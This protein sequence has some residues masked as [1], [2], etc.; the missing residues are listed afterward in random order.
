MKKLL[1]LLKKL[2]IFFNKNI[3][4]V[5]TITQ[6]NHGEILKGKR[7]LITG[8]TSGI[9]LALAKKCLSEGAV[10][11]I[12]GRSLERLENISKE[13]SNK[14]LKVLEWNVKNI[15]DIDVNIE[16]VISLI[17]GVNIVFNNAGIYSD[18]KFLE[19]TEKEYDNILDTNLKSIFFI[20]QK[21][22]EYFKNNKVKGKIINTVSI[23][24]Y[25]STRE[26]YGISKWGLLGL[27]KGLA[28]ELTKDG[29]IV[30]GIAP[31]VTA[32]GINGLDMKKDI[33]SNSTL[34][35]RVALPEEIAEI[36]C[37]LASDASNHII[38]QVIVCD[39]GETL[40]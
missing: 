23:R 12:T 33:F 13:I 30:N 38:G 20:S 5:E 35:G 2:Y 18:N 37:F 39:G 25:Q 17:G 22:A 1:N 6:I 11:V 27:T 9:G 24:G 8:G 14:N 4:K 16:K 40:L 3:V 34:D 10:V 15:S 21:I 31:G 36:G 32:S 28:K 7:V 29:I 19:V 26:P